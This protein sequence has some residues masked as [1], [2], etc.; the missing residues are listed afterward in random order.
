MVPVSNFLYIIR[1]GHVNVTFRGNDDDSGG[2]H[3]YNL[4]VITRGE[5]FGE[6]SLLTGDNVSVCVNE[7]PLVMLAGVAL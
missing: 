2:R 3:V 6:K 5:C 1:D 7:S 4:G